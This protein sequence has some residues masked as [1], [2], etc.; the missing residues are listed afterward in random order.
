MYT[1]YN[2]Y[3]FK[4][5]LIFIIIYTFFLAASILFLGFRNFS[6]FLFYCYVLFVLLMSLELLVSGIGN[7]RKPTSGHG[8]MESA[9]KALGPQIV[10]RD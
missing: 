8:S 7:H 4:Y 1:M 9:V 3:L 6:A 5:I 2:L 10:Q